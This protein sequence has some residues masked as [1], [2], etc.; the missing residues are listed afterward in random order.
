MDL[1]LIFDGDK[2]HLSIKYFDRFMFHKA[3][4][5]NKKYFCESCLQCFSSI[6][7]LIEHRKACLNINDAQSVKLKKGK[8]EFKNLFKQILVPFKT[9]SDFECILNIVESYE[10]FC[11]KNIKFTFLVVLLIN[12]FVLMIN[13]VSQ[14]LLTEVKMLLINLL[15]K[16]LKNMNTAKK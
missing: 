7:V 6:N 1:L 2:S 9:Y 11:S 4:K 13:L 15:K 16:L 12:L 10:G 3:K 14:L 5:E 8:I